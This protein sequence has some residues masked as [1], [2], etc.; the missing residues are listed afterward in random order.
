MLEFSAINIWAVLV[1]WVI[2]LIIG[3]FWYSPAGFA[4]K[5]KQYTKIDIMKIPTDKATNILVFV[6]ISSLV[7][8]F[9]LAVIL[10]SLSVTTVGEGLLAGLVIW[11]GLTTATT[12][13]TTLYS[14]LSWKFLW[15]NSA[16]FL[17]VMGI[18]SIILSL[19][20]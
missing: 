7:Q 12:V 13:G 18:G 14:R 20:K 16:Y 1:V 3:A 4:N 15:L 5:W 9:T 10:A 17:V 8:A 2:Y 19:W 6:T 11:L